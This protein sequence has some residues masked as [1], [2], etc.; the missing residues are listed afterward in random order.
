MTFRAA[1]WTAAEGAVGSCGQ[2]SFSSYSLW[3]CRCVAVL[4]VCIWHCETAVSSICGMPAL[5]Y[6]VLGEFSS[7][8]LTTAHVLSCVNAVRIPLR[9]L[10]LFLCQNIV[11]RVDRLSV[12]LRPQLWTRAAS[13]F[14][15]KCLCYLK[16]DLESAT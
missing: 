5:L 9:T 16:T 3:L 14:P 2:C 7:V 13:Q 10:Q 12:L 4:H 15:T 8:K 11:L 6:V 1:I